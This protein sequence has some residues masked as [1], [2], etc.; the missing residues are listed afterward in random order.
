MVGASGTDRVLEH[1]TLYGEHAQQA[2][3]LEA[4]VVVENVHSLGE[5]ADF[6]DGGPH[7][8]GAFAPAHDLPYPAVLV[9]VD[10]R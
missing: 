5:A 7:F 4:V 3:D 9:L 6:G 10:L 1:H 2:V 8:R